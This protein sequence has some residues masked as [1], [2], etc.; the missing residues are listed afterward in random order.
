MKIIEDTKELNMPLVPMI[1]RYFPNTSFC[2]FDLETLGL[3]KK[4]D[5]IVLSGMVFPKG[6][7]AHVKQYFAE[8]REEEPFVLEQTRKDLS[9]C[10]L[11][12]TYNGSRFDIPFFKARCDLWNI[13]FP[14]FAY[15]L[16]L[17]AL[18]RHFSTLSKKLPNLKQKTLENFMGLW[19]CRYDEISGKESVSLYKEYVTYHKK[20]DLEKILGHNHDDIL[21]LYRLLAVSEKT[22]YHKAFTH[23]GFPLKVEDQWFI[24]KKIKVEKECIRVEGHH[25]P[26]PVNYVH[27]GE[28]EITAH[29]SHHSFSFSIPTIQ[30]ENLLL[31]DGKI[32]KI[33]KNTTAQGYFI[34]AK[35]DNYQYHKINQCIAQY[36]ERIGKRWT[37]NN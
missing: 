9:T 35:E 13:P 24:V 25:H 33:E 30:V 1:S 32:N 8:N 23:W 4:K 3:N 37:I 5:A 18:V 19:N 28:K 21:Q 7:C 11:V 26:H 22:D 34:I 17:Y 36:I 27:F 29:F 20:E 15:H 14:N 16:D 2:V 31:I 10:D 12:I 6:D